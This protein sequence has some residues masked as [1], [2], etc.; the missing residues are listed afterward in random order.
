MTERYSPDAWRRAADQS[1]LRSVARRG[2]RRRRR[3]TKIDV[4]G[5]VG[6]VVLVSAGVFAVLFT[7]GWI[8][9]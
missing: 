2:Q 7:A 4:I 8:H 5:V 1:Y 6:L 9:V 3:F